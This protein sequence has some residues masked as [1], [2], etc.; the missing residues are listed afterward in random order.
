MQGYC[1]MC[2]KCCE[3]I[4]LWVSPE[5]IARGANEAESTDFGWAA[6]HFRPISREEAFRR[7][8]LHRLIAESGRNEYQGVHFYECDAYDKQTKRCTQHDKRPQVCRRYPHYGNLSLDGSW[9]PYSA[10]CDYIHD[11]PPASKQLMI[12]LALEMQK[13]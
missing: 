12:E 5:E 2:G 9:L 7:N 1:N 10:T 13:A 8:P 4:T 11:M 6:R 3:A